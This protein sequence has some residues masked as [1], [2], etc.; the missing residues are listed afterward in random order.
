ME[1][2][3]SK[4]VLLFLFTPAL[5]CLL[6]CILTKTAPYSASIWDKISAPVLCVPTRADNSHRHL[7]RTVMIAMTI[8]IIFCC[9]RAGNRTTSCATHATLRTGS[10]ETSRR[11]H[12]TSHR[13]FWQ[14]RGQPQLRRWHR[15][16]AMPLPMGRG[17]GGVMPRKVL[18]CFLWMGPALWTPSTQVEPFTRAS[19]VTSAA[20]APSW[21][22]ATSPMCE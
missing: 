5:A 4:Q 10:T 11:S 18:G 1:Y 9:M 19:S 8:T 12:P 15:G 6:Q 7:F 22:L 14:R 13:L 2:C 3:S 17:L 16:G 21:G 20:C